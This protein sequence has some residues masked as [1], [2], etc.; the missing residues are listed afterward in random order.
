MVIIFSLLKGLVSVIL[1]L[2]SILGLQVNKTTVE[3]YANP[4]SGYEWE[5]SF[6]EQGIMVLNDSHYSPD[7]ASI[8]SGK[9]GGTQ[10]F[11]FRALDSG[12]VNITFEYVKYNGAQ[13]IVASTYVYTYMVD[14]IGGIAL[15]QVQ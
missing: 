3:L 14:S 10:Y 2:M 8:L 6:D 5:Y 7:T 13:R 4:S 11:T 12:T 1:A 9:G 15:Y